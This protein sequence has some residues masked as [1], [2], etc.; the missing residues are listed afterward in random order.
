MIYFQKFGGET[1][2][3]K[4]RISDKYGMGHFKASR[5]E[6]EHNGI[7]LLAE[8]AS[9]LL[10]NVAGKVTKWGYP[11]GHPHKKWLRYVE[12]Q[13][14]SELRHRFFYLLPVA[15]MGSF[16]E[17]GDPIGIVQDLEIVYPG[18]KTHCHYEIILNGSY[19]DPTPFA[20]D[21]ETT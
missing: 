11:Y 19:L 2:P 7:D 10:S 20:L 14:E 6:K 15:E 3:A 21:E 17:P 12:V 4:L 16:V 9:V 18:I 1:Y 8:P 5:G 13:D